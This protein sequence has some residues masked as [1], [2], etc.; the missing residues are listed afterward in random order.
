MITRTVT[1]VA[2]QDAIERY[3]PGAALRN[4]PGLN[5]GIVSAAFPVD[6]TKCKSALGRWLAEHILTT[7]FDDD[8][9]LVKI[10]IPATEEGLHIK[11]LAKKLAQQQRVESAA[12]AEAVYAGLEKWINERRKLLMVYG[13]ALFEYRVIAFNWPVFGSRA[14]G[15]AL[16]PEAYFD[17]CAKMMRTTGGVILKTGFG[18]VPPDSLLNSM[19]SD[20]GGG[21]ALLAKHRGQENAVIGDGK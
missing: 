7:R 11:E 17:E 13:S 3:H 18:E 21:L 15:G 8:A 20:V 14:A 6:P 19:A 16:T 4:D 5:P 10:V 9:S 12:E 1:L 2:N